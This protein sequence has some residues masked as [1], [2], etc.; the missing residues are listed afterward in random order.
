MVTFTAFPAS[1]AGHHPGRTSS[2]QTQEGPT[3]L[4]LPVCLPFPS[5][6]QFAVLFYM[7]KTKEFIFIKCS[8]RL[9]DISPIFQRC[10]IPLLPLSANASLML[11]AGEA[12]L[13]MVPKWE[14]SQAVPWHTDA[15]RQRT[16]LVPS[17]FTAFQG[18]R[19]KTSNIM[20]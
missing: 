8:T 15:G 5:L 13:H 12:G 19:L 9:F 14:W 20:F 1:L 6:P 16:L 7:A 11:S 2:A 10:Q 4:Q 17:A 3:V 18:G